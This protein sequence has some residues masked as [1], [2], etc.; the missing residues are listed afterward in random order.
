MKCLSCIPFPLSADPF[1]IFT[2]PCHIFMATHHKNADYHQPLQF[3]VCF[4]L[5]IHNIT[6][7]DWNLVLDQSPVKP[8]VLISLSGKQNSHWWSIFLHSLGAW[9]PMSLLGPE[10]PRPSHLYRHPH[11]TVAIWNHLCHFRGSRALVLQ[12]FMS[13]CRKEFSEKQRGR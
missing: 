13:Q 6:H 2:V 3:F 7:S 12:F 10:T 5:Y 8:L 11:K 4:P 1:H 9:H